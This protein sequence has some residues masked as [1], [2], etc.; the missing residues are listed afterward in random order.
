[1]V[2]YGKRGCVLCGIH[3][4]TLNGPRLKRAQYKLVSADSHCMAPVGFRAGPGKGHYLRAHVRSG[5][6]EKRPCLTSHPAID[7]RRTAGVVIADKLDLKFRWC[8][9]GRLLQAHGQFQRLG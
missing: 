3:L 9:W 2:A 4:T 8:G 7:I 5:N 1:M 6:P